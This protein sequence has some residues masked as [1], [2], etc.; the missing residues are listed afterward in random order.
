MTNHRSFSFYELMPDGRFKF[1]VD[2]SLLRSFAHCEAYFYE[3]HVRNLRQKGLPGVKPF[4]MAIGSWWSDVMEL[5]Y[6]ALRDKR[7]L[8]T[9]MIKDIALTC[10][11]S[12]SLDACAAASP[13]QFDE[14]GDL[15]GA[16]LMLH[17]YY[18]TQYVVDKQSWKIVSV[19]EGFGL[20]N[21]VL[22]GETRNVVVYWIGRP[23]LTVV[24]NGR[25]TPV[26][27]KT[28]ARVEGSTV[29]KYKPST[30]LAGY[31]HSCE[32]IARGLGLDVR[33]DRCV[34][35][36][37]SRS[38]PTDKPRSGKKRPRFIRAYPNFTREEIAEW[39]RD[40][41]NKCERIAHCLK[42]GDW[43]WSE[44][45]CHNMYM[46]PCEFLPLH[47]ATPSARPVVLQASFETGQPWTPYFVPKEDS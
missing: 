44:T 39:R 23:D 12:N 47:S 17:E 30:Q 19:E 34:V 3:R 6:N 13:K 33:T 26:D 29:S 40:V 32:T 42:T 10:W 31:V 43:T 20:R 41:I 18:D 14:F 38:R 28:V 24:E 36:I 4:A 2:A 5:F 45:S 7:E 25:L 22:L 15:S 37:C 35:N 46:R 11:A 1:Y 8:D 16:V 27:H 21:E 9:P